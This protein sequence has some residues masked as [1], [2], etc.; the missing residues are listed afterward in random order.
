MVNS[1]SAG[2]DVPARWTDA[3]DAFVAEERVDDAV[4]DRRRER[5]SRERRAEAT[6]LRDALRGS[7][8]SVCTLHLCT[9]DRATGTVVA[10]GSDVVELDAAH[11]DRSWI[12]LVGI[13]AAEVEP[14]R[15]ATGSAGD[16]MSLASVLEDLRAERA[17]VALTL[18]GGTVLSGEV[19]ASGDAVTL[20][21]GA[22]TAGTSQ[23][24]LVDP[25]AVV[26]VRRTG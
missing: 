23:V 8:G 11:G 5:W 13:V 22:E 21:H 7:T 26:L 9:G 2:G 10:V 25:A 3:A 12:A 19:T 4:A 1:D 6:T 15:R 17:V 18:D 20:A 16:A 24:T 14:G